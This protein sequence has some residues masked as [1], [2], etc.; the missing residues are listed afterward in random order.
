M[1]RKSGQGTGSGRPAKS[2]GG[3]LCVKLAE[4]FRVEIESSLRDFMRSDSENG[5]KTNFQSQIIH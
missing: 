4:D 5:K 3:G 2:E 1:P